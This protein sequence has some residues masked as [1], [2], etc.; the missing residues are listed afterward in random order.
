MN[1]TAIT[2]SV[3]PRTLGGVTFTDGTLEDLEDWLAALPTDPQEAAKRLRNG[4]MELNRAEGYF[5]ARF[6]EL[7]LLRP[8]VRRLCR[9]LVATGDLQRLA[10][11]L[12]TELATGYKGS[13]RGDP[14]GEGAPR[15][16][17]PG[18]LADGHGHRLHPSCPE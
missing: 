11:G 16:G 12:Q 14:R 9:R 3:P 8:T 2:L 17:Q 5:T 10:Q 13:R 4:V 15:S 7:E 1:D 18:R 6:P